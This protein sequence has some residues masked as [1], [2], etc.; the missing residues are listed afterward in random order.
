MILIFIN[1]H[2]KNQI[3]EMIN[4]EFHFNS[5]QIPITAMRMGKGKYALNGVI[6]FLKTKK[7]DTNTPRGSNCFH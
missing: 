7:I 3:K 6:L 1:R 5:I 2:H 4:S